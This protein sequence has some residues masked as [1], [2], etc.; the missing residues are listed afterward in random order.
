MNSSLWFKRILGIMTIVSALTTYA[1][2]YYSED[3]FTAI[4][5]AKIRTHHYD[6]SSS[7]RYNRSTSQSIQIPRLLVKEM[8]QTSIETPELSSIEGQGSANQAEAPNTAASAP[9]EQRPTAAATNP[10]NIT[11]NNSSQGVSMRAYISQ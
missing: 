1:D 2:E 8:E 7:L 5:E 9:L 11:L 10:S 3:I 6:Y 4:A